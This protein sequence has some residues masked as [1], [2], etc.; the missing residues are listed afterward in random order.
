MGA[1]LAL[2]ISAEEGTGFMDFHGYARC[3]RIE[4]GDTRVTFGPHCGGRVLEYAWRGT[5][6][7][8]LNPAQAGWLYAPGKAPIDPMGGRFDIGPEHTIPRHPTLWLEAWSA[9]LTGPRAVRMTSRPDPATGVQLIRDFALAATSSCLTVRQTIRNVTADTLH[10]CHWSRTLAV[11]NG[12]AIVPLT[13]PSRFP[14]HYLMYGPGPV[15]NY[16]PEDPSIRVR[17][18]CLEIIG[19]PAQP[20]LGM[21]S[22]AGW[23]AYLTRANILFLK[24]F[25]VYPDRV[26]NEMAALTVSIYYL[27]DVMC[28]LEPIGPRE[29][30]RPGES[31]SFT[32]EWWLFPFPFPSAGAA[33]DLKAVRVFVQQ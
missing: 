5:N 13:P 23:L 29:T 17:D 32:E 9:E 14:K 15:M 27:D 11:G 26:Y 4:N 8:H 7:L 33:P 1:T 19:P 12:I 3:P 30:L 28:E 22:S 2:A 24:R 25:P 20:K 31:A 10:W 16:Q 21:D 18:G 6:V